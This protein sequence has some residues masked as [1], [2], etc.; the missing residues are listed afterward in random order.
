MQR[1][2]YNYHAWKNSLRELALELA[3]AL[4]L[5][6][7]ARVEK[8]AKAEVRLAWPP[9]VCNSFVEAYPGLDVKTLI[10]EIL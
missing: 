2:F 4:A 8:L 1:Y 3:Q 6:L 9:S 5:E 10:P 7:K